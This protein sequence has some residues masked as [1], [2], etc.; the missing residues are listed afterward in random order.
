MNDLQNKIVIEARSW[1]GTRFRHQGHQK[2]VG[3]DCSGLIRGVL[4]NVIGLRYED[5]W[6]Y[7]HRPHAPALLELLDKYLMRIPTG[8]AQP[9]DILLFKVD[10]NPQHLAIKT[11]R[12]MIHAYAWGPRRVEEVSSPPPGLQGPVGCWRCKRGLNSVR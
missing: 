2:G 1:L 4:E 5:V 10:N 6:N 12:G 7:P 3:C 11:D 8:E 9:G